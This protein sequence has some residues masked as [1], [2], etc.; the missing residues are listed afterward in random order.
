VGTYRDGSG[1]LGVVE[2]GVATAGHHLGRRRRGSFGAEQSV[3]Q[4]GGSSA[5]RVK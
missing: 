2:G 1:G 4:Q 5:G 3:W